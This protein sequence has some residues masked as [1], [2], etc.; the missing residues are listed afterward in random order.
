MIDALLDALVVASV[1]A[2][3]PCIHIAMVAHS[4]C[5]LKVP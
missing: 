5:C 3:T 1:L 2:D 4:R